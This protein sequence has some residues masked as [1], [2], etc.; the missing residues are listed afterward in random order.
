MT[1]KP[2]PTKKAEV[3]GYNARQ[4]PINAKL[5][6]DEL[7]ALYRDMIR[8]RRFEERCLRSYQ[9]GKGTDGHAADGRSREYRSAK[10]SKESPAWR[11]R[12]R[13]TRFKHAFLYAMTA[14][15]L[16]NPVHPS[17]TFACVS[18]PFLK[19]RNLAPLILL[20]TQTISL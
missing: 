5:G 17:Q 10:S 19:R 1:K 8:I 16:G 4:A 2:A 13:F 11:S 9:Q 14:Q 6:N 12:G 20:Q 15:F 3:A 18:P 7:I